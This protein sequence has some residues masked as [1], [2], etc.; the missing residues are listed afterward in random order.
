MGYV[1]PQIILP[2]VASTLKFDV[3]ALARDFT[4]DWLT[5]IRGRQFGRRDRG[6]EDYRVYSLRILGRL[7]A[8]EYAREF[9][10]YEEELI[11]EVKQ[12]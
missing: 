1:P 6:R 12:V 7:G 8:W 10:R 2:V 11:E 4:E 9:M 3:V 5:K